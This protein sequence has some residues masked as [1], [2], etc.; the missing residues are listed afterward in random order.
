MILNEKETEWPKVDSLICFYSE[1]FP[2]YK[3]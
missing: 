2:L 3:A 1:G